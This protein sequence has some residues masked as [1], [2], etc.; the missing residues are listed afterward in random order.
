MSDPSGRAAA[1][2]TS[3]EVEP[4]GRGAAVEHPLRLG[5]RVP[6]RSGTSPGSDTGG[7]RGTGIS[8]IDQQ[9]ERAERAEQRPRLSTSRAAES[10]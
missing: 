6:V 9:T 5:P 4:L 7:G 2:G 3:G 10:D 8:G 1:L